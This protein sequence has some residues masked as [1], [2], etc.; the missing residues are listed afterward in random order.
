[1]KLKLDVG[2]KE[3]Y[4]ITNEIVTQTRGWNNGPMVTTESFLNAKQDVTV[5][6]DKLVRTRT[7]QAEAGAR[8]DSS[9]QKAADGVIRQMASAAEGSVLEGEY[10]ARGRGLN[11]YLLGDGVGLNPMGPQ[12]GAQEVMVGF[13][14]I[15]FPEK[16]VKVGDKWQAVYDITASAQDLFQSS[17][18]MVENGEIPIAYELLE[19][20]KETNFIKL[21]LSSKGSPVVKI[22]IGSGLAKIEMTVEAKGQALVHFDTGWLQELRFETSVV[23]EGFVATKQVVKT[24]TRRAKA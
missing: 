20:N 8:G 5:R 6:P 15:V 1:M 10:D 19:Y 7:Y 24:V 3:T 22:P 16:P 9:E 14:G 12:A 4:V 21:G 2:R 17:G 11:L 18:G 13:M 23:T